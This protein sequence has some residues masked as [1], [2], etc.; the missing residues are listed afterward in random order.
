MQQGGKNSFRKHDGQ[1][2]LLHR[3]GRLVAV[4][5]LDDVIAE[6]RVQRAVRR[7]KRAGEHH[8]IESRH[9]RALFELA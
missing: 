1:R 8:F 5:H 9:H 2:K 7:D 4:Q 6:L 3:Q